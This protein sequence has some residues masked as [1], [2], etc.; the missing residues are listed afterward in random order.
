MIP[1]PSPPRPLPQ[2]ALVTGASSGIGL[3]L[4]ELLLASSPGIAVVAVA[5]SAAT[6]STLDALQQRFGNRLHRID[7]DLTRPAAMATLADSVRTSVGTLDWVVHAAGM[8]HGE[9]I[10]PEKSVR[11]V[12]HDALQQ[13]FALNA[14]APILLARALLPFLPKDRP[15]VFVAIS[16]R[17]GSIGDNQLGGWYA[18]RAS[19]AAQNQFMRTLAIELRRTHPQMVCANLHPGTVDTPLSKPFQRGVAADKLFSPGRA[20]RYLLDVITQ[21]SPEQSGRFHAWDGSE[22]PW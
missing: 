11:D 6:A 2:T 5:R 8:L 14:F 12:S 17:V 18:Y 9:R 13:V 3:A 7:A 16:A 10:A 20:A 21:L 19:K 4:C 1:L 22:I 15:G